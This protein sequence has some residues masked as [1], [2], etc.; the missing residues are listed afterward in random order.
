ML[1]HVVR[2]PSNGINIYKQMELL[3]NYLLHVIS[4]A[5]NSDLCQG[6]PEGPKEHTKTI[7]LAKSGN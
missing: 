5:T 6:V 4:K 1:T 3:K 7:S 2:V